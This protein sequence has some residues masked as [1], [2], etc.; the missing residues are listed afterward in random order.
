[1]TGKLEYN[2]FTFDCVTTSAVLFRPRRKCNQLESDIRL[3]GYEY[4]QMSGG[5]FS[6]K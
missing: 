5:N 4:E 6:E 1:M 3:D 2:G